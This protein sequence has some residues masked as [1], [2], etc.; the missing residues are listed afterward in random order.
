MVE[1]ILEDALRAWQDGSQLLDSLPSLSP[2]HEIARRAVGSL[3]S[4]YEDTTARRHRGPSSLSAARTAITT[5][6]E[7]LESVR[8]RNETL[9]GDSARTGTTIEQIE[10]T[11][12]QAEALLEH[13]TPYS[14]EYDRIQSAI[15]ELRQLEAMAD[16]GP[17]LGP[18]DAVVRRAIV[19]T[20]VTIARAVDA[21]SER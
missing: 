2:D 1:T 12:E 10:R 8:A 13:M 14:A 18:S 19:E 17:G 6:Q 20:Q 3:R 9:T 4:V 5:A 21:S 11:L 15:V 16:A 7:T